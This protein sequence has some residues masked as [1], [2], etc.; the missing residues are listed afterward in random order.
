MIGMK[1]KLF[2]W[3][4]DT[5]TISSIGVMIAFLQLE[6]ELILF[7]CSWISLVFFAL[8]TLAN[9]CNDYYLYSGK[10][11]FRARVINCAGNIVLT[12]FC[13]IAKSIVPFIFG[14][15]ST[16]L[17]IVSIGL[18]KIYRP[19]L[20]E[21]EIR[22]TNGNNIV[23]KNESKKSLISKEKKDTDTQIKPVFNDYDSA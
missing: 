18:D 7:I 2:I 20:K 10:C 16:I 5:L 13:L 12:C 3:F 9:I 19:K 1:I 23:D 17:I 22:E 6:D 14:I 15:I 21:I 8:T 11:N 4:I